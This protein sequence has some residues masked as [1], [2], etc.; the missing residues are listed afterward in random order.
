MIIITLKCKLTGTNDWTE[1]VGVRGGLYTV[2]TNI[3]KILMSA[4][5]RAIL[6]FQEQLQFPS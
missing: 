3:I 1:D 5:H 6:P 4:L 2:Y